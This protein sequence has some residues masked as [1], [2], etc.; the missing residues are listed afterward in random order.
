[1]VRALV[2]PL[3]FG[4]GGLLGARRCLSRMFVNVPRFI[5]ERVELCLA[6]AIGSFTFRPAGGEDAAGPATDVG[7]DVHFAL[8]A[9]EG[10]LAEDERGDDGIGVADVEG[11]GG[12]HVGS[13]FSPG[14][15]KISAAESLPMNTSRFAGGASLKIRANASPLIAH[16]RPVRICSASYG[17]SVSPAPPS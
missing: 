5:G 2:N 4:R 8:V 1:M 10:A 16:I 14:F 7:F 17:S 9:E 11:D 6:P 13:F 12:F 15:P 3:S